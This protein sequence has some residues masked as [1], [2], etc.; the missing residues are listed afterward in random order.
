ML[1]K[2]LVTYEDMGLVQWGVLDE[3]E[4]GVYG[5]IALE[6]AFLRRCRKRFS[7]SSVRE[8]KACWP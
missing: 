8:M 6:E 5:A 1:I 4:T 2:K 3:T 7:N